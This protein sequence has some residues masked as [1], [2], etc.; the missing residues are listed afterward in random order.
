ME[1]TQWLPMLFNGLSL[2]VASCFAYFVYCQFKVYKKSFKLKDIWFI[3]VYLVIFVLRIAILIVDYTYPD[4]D[5]V[6]RVILSSAH[7]STR[8]A[9]LSI[10]LY[11]LLEV[12]KYLILL[13]AKNVQDREKKKA[14][15]LNTF[16]WILSFLIICNISKIFIDLHYWDRN[17]NSAP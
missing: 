8:T 1:W 5:F 10:D 6:Q 2:L 15:K 14:N 17:D 4:N 16:W 7:S 12:Q 13:K 3:W 11:Y 9:I